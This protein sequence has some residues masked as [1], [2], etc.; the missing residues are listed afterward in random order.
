MK[1]G[2]WVKI[3][4]GAV[5]TLGNLD[6]PYSVVE[7]LL[8]HTVDVDCGNEWTINGYSKMW[9]WSR[10]KVRRFINSLRTHSGHIADRKGTQSGHPVHLISKAPQLVAD[11]KRTH[12][13]HIADN[14]RVWCWLK[15]LLNI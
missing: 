13:G 2:N 15:R 6:R 14:K 12:S 11:T 8:S 10:G 7:A 9:K 1:Q 5:K 3:D 4:K